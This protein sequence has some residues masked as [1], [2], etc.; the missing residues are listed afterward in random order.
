MI[1]EG[2]ASKVWFDGHMIPSDQAVVSIFDRSFQLGDGLF[3]TVRVHRGVPMQWHLH[4]E[5]LQM[6]AKTLRI[7]IPF[8]AAEIT[9]AA[10]SLIRD[11]SVPE[12][13]LR[14]T[15]SRGVGPRGYSPQGADQ[16]RL[17][18]T[19]HP[20]PHPE[21][22]APAGWN[23]ATSRFRIPTENPL[24]PFKTAGKLL[25]IMARMEAEDAGADDALLLDTNHH[26][27]EASSGNLFWIENGVVCTPPPATGALPGVTR[28][29]VLRLCVRLG[30]KSAQVLR[31]RVA[32]ADA[33]GSFVTLSSLGIVPVTR[34]DGDRV[35]ESP[36]TER[37]RLAYW[38]DAANAGTP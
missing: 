38:E 20:L 7:R 12:G 32:M 30:L 15:L 37:L 24:S 19:L 10:R 9:E 36:L 34:L 16:P 35:K 31:P 4:L 28:E 6:G 27:A 3:E 14:L 33:D 29:V 25:Q 26:L 17:A 22:R 8:E 11:Q 2:S 5:R 18:L 13:I 23:L 1:P 21:D